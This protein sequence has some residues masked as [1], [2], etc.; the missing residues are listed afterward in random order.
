[1]FFGRLFGWLL[2]LLAVFTASA[3]AVA[4]LGAGEHVGLATSDVLTIITGLSV[5][6]NG[7]LI[8]RLLRWPAWLSMGAV[9]LAL[10]FLC[11]KKKYKTAFSPKGE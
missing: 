9:G 3:E 4:A 7:S 11:R 5:E 2:L 1:M 10:I 6:P 8:E